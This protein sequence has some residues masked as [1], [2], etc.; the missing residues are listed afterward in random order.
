MQIISDKEE[1]IFRSEYNGKP[2]FSIGLSK[3]S[4]DGNYVNGYMEVHF[5]NG[6]DLPN[7]TRIKIKEAW[8]GFNQK[9][10]KTYTY[11]FINDFDMAEETNPFEEFGD[12][13]KTESDIGEQ[14][15]IQESDLPF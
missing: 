7:K 4:K 1:M 10:K 5:K 9:E 14:I 3:K 8:L 13:I 11:I 6:V 12:S 2:I 15:Q